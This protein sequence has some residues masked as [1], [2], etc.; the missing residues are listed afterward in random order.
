[1]NMNRGMVANFGVLLVLSSAWMASTA[2]AQTFTPTPYA[3]GPVYGGTSTLDLSGEALFALDVMQIT[4][5]GYD[6][7]TSTYAKDSDGHYAQMSM[8][9]PAV[10]VDM[11]TDT[12]G[13]Y[14]THS[15]GGVT[16]TAPI[17]RKL[18]TGG[19]LTITD[20]S[21]DFGTKIISGTVIGANG[22]GTVSNTPL[23]NVSN[24]SSSVR[25]C[26]DVGLCDAI[27]H[28]NYEYL[29]SATATGL[30]LTEQG[31]ATFVQALGFSSTAQYLVL[32]SVEDFGSLTTQTY[33]VATE[34]LHAVPE[35]ATWTLMGL[36]LVGLMGIRRR[37]S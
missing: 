34:N 16:F 13:V 2:T 15:S 30:S 20:L 12:M 4:A 9:A 19:S 18:S 31:Q 36:G 8:V 28:P 14:A 35:P 3:V 6:L 26:P 7:G 33:M 17:V 27:G 21:L 22:L 24:I 10:S 25:G 11:D 23:W 32:A 1:M 5:T 29:L 37:Q